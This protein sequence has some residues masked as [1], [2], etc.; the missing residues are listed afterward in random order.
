VLTL[1]LTTLREKVI[2]VGA[3]VVHHA[4]AVM[5]PRELFAAIL[6]RIGRLRVAPI[7]G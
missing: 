5:F 4:R 6:A 2:R 3:N 1:T 7:P